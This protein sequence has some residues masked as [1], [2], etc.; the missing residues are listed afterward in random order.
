MSCQHASVE[1]G[2]HRLILEKERAIAA[3]ALGLVLSNRLRHQHNVALRCGLFPHRLGVGVSTA[4]RAV[5][6]ALDISAAFAIST[7][8][9][10]LLDALVLFVVNCLGR[11]DG[12]DFRWFSLNSVR[13][14]A[15]VRVEQATRR[16]RK[17]ATVQW[18]APQTDGPSNRCPLA[19]AHRT[20]SAR[21]GARCC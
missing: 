19:I 17:S 21:P 1:V 9:G 4:G 20:R 7:R 10:C 5:E 16:S 8:G 18:R 15:S 11:H 2:E 13:V 12:A 14:D 6:V 3:N